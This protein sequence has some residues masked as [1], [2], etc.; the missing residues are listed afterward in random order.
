MERET[1]MSKKF[2]RKEEETGVVSAFLTRK[3]S[4]RGNDTYNPSPSTSIFYG[5]PMKLH[6]VNEEAYTPQVVAIGPLHRTK[7][8]LQPMQPRKDRYLNYFVERTKYDRNR[9]FK[10]VK[11]QEQNARGYY[12]DDINLNP[13]EFSNLLLVDGIFI[14]EFFLRM[15]SH[16]QAGVDDYGNGD[17]IFKKHILRDDIFIDLILLE[18]QL[19]F[20]VLRDLYKS[21][22]LDPSWEH[23]M[24]W[25]AREYFKRGV[26]FEKTR[27]TLERNDIWHLVDFLHSLCVATVPKKK[28]H[29]EVQPNIE[30]SRS[31]TELR[32]AGV[33]FVMAAAKYP[34]DLSF[35]DDGLLEIPSMLIDRWTEYFFRNFIAHEHCVHRD[36]IISSYIIL[37]SSLLKTP[38]D[39]DLLVQLKIIDNQSLG[40]SEDLCSLFRR[41][42][43]RSMMDKSEFYYAALCEDLN[44]Y[45]EEYWH[46]WKAAL[47]IWE[48]RLRHNYF[49]SLW[50]IIS[51]IAG[52]ILLVLAIIQAMNPV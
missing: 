37:M 27:E 13:D 18:N 46:Q 51:V 22:E 6:K 7:R 45:S 10:M 24:F 31:A 41:L 36:K 38:K 52:F 34:F 33:H 43:R 20:F 14:I 9:Y 4:S 28:L 16:K 44:N 26:S 19:P 42:Y 25:I 1:S 17:E 40:T 35:T 32:E 30:L 3:L 12:Q 50:S 39:A 48:E 2:R 8:H 23:L 21:S 47:H 11:E 5:I 15:R 29:S 49:G